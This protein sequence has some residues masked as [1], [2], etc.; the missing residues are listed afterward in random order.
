MKKDKIGLLVPTR[1]RPGSIKAIA[2]EYKKYGHGYV[3]IIIGVDD[4]D[5]NL[6]DYEN[7]ANEYGLQ[8][9]VGARKRLGPTLNDMA[10]LFAEDYFAL[11]FIGDDMRPRTQGWDGKIL[12]S[13]HGLKTGFTHGDDG[14]WGD[15][16][17]TQVFLTSD[18]VEQLGYMVPPGIIHM[19]L[20]NFW[21]D[22]ARKIDRFEYHGDILIEHL[23]P[24]WGKAE[25]DDLYAE[26][27]NSERMNADRILYE[28][29]K[30][31]RMDEDV[32]K[33][34]E[35]IEQSKNMH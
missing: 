25:H 33:I 21:S 13:L 19:Y 32:R 3:D 2:E 6:H 9:I 34:T 17:A 28:E 12:G 31:G 20:D 5:I 35:Y 4:D 11:G 22:F 16:L 27:N 24:A 14:A 10:V 18:I 26:T 1:N 23:H 30:A 7:V 29:Y 8:M 15:Q